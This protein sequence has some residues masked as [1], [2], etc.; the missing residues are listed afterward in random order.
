ML[1]FNK[2]ASALGTIELPQK[3]VQVIDQ[4]SKSGE[5]VIK[6]ICSKIENQEVV[7]LAEMKKIFPLSLSYL[8]NIF[9]SIRNQYSKDYDIVK[10]SPGCY[11]F[12][13]K[14]KF[15]FSSYDDE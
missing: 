1:P 13:K 3:P 10:K 14:V 6:Y 8:S 15:I 4:K 12:F 7:S 9:S 11:A 5:D 2:L